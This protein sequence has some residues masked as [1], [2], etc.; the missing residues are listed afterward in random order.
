[1]LLASHNPVLVPAFADPTCWG[2]ALVCLYVEVEV[3][4]RLLARAGVGG[5]WVRDRLVLLQLVSWAGFLVALDQLAVTSADWAMLAGM[6]GAVVLVEAAAMRC[7]FARSPVRATFGSWPRLLWWSA[8]GN[9]ASAGLC[10]LV[11]A[12]VRWLV[13]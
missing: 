9:L 10:L 1:M 11:V 3:L 13:A 6:E 8:A 12:L 4:R 2:V 5:G 7:V